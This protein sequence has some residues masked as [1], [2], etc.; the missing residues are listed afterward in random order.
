MTRFPNI[1]LVGSNATG[2]LENAYMRA[3]Q[4]A[5]VQHVEIF[6]IDICKFSLQGSSI[7]KRAVNRLLSPASTQRIRRKF[8]QFL[9]SKRDKY[10]VVIIFKGMWASREL[11]ETCR[12][13]HPAIWVNINP[14]DP[15][16]L[17]SRGS[18]NMHVIHS[19]SFY[20]I[21]CTWARSLVDRLRREGC[22]H[23]EY[24]PF[25]YDPDFHILPAQLV[26]ESGTV[27]FAG[28]WDSE[29]EAI[30]TEISNYDLRIFGNNWDRV[31][32]VSPI[33]KK[34]VP[35]N[36]YGNELSKVVYGSAVSLNLLRPQNSGSHNM[37]TFEIPAMGGLMLT[38][39]SLE[40]NEFFPE[41]EGCLMFDDIKEVRGQLDRL[42]K[43]P[44]LRQRIR[45]RGLELA[46]GNSYLD[47]AKALLAMIGS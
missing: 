14:D 43:S 9:Y 17:R 20:D 4:K 41:E 6:N 47:R 16:N 44:G 5:G 12:L 11:L 2:S 21:Y 10:D 15:F 28:A 45:R 31:S 29:R 8:L 13:I 22:Q 7:V 23:V 33:Y 32:K 34:V 27:S 1:I 30:L 26:I 39:R 40:Q 38:T 18:T 42:I 37:R 35:R 19:L 24:L 3:L 25:G 46:N 36:I